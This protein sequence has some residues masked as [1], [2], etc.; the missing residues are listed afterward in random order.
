[1]TKQ[2]KNKP[3]AVKSSLTL[4]VL[5]GCEVYNASPEEAARKVV[6]DLLE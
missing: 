6:T 2:P 4:Q 5:W 3:Q 1:M